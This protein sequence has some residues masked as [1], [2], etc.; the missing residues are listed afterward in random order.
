MLKDEALGRMDVCECAVFACR[1]HCLSL[2]DMLGRKKD[3]EL[4]T[5]SVNE[6]VN[7]LGGLPNEC[8]EKTRLIKCLNMLDKMADYL[9]CGLR[10]KGCQ[11]NHLGLHIFLSQH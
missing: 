7:K 1:Q 2:A 10:S 8:F 11:Q 9:H 4:D 3:M 5:I 6:T